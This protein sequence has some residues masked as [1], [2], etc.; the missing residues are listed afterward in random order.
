MPLQTHSI[1]HKEARHL[2]KVALNSAHSH[3]VPGAIAIV[4]QGG[5]PVLLEVLDG[6]MH[7]A[8]NIALGKAATAVAFQR[9]TGKLEEVI[10]DG[11]APMLTLDSCTPQP[12]VPLLGGHP[13]YSND[14]IIG[15]IAVAGTL[16]A[17]LDEVIVLDA[18]KEWRS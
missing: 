4:D 16:N 13:I 15:G 14:K 7:A 11:R 5:H 2:M 8:A 17:Q 6:T 18:L 1:S 3:K 12:Y 9:P 10:S